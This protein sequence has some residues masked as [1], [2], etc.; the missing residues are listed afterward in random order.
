VTGYEIIFFWVAR[1][2]MSG[3][4]LWDRSLLKEV[5]IHGIVRDEHGAKMSNLWAMWW[6]H[7]D[8]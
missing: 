8:H 5:Y 4:E 3:L 1:M 7:C 6:I 2:M